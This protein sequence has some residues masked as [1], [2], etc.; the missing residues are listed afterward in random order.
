MAPRFA[1]ER[2]SMS[3]QAVPKPAM[4][5]ATTKHPNIDQAYKASHNHPSPEQAPHMQRRIVAEQRPNRIAEQCPRQ[6][7]AR[8]PTGCPPREAASAIHKCLDQV[9][10]RQFWLCIAPRTM[11]KTKANALQQKALDTHEAESRKTQHDHNPLQ[12]AEHPHSKPRRQLAAKRHQLE[13]T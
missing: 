7:Q 4:R 6:T 12:S 3:K 2:E 10:T 9:T 13:H 8:S 11:A 5:R 1:T